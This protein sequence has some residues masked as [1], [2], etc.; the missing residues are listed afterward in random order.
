MI[1]EHLGLDRGHV[2]HLLSE[3]LVMVPLAGTGE[4]PHPAA[5]GHVVDLVGDDLAQADIAVLEP[6]GVTAPEDPCLEFIAAV[7]YSPASLYPEELRMQDVAI[8]EH[9]V[10]L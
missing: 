5:L 2:G 9:V 7:L 3:R 8:E 10:G 4:G 6:Q 1:R